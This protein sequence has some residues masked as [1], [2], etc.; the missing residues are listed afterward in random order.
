MDFSTTIADLKND[1]LSHL[2]LAL[3]DER[4]EVEINEDGAVSAIFGVTLAFHRE[5]GLKDGIVDSDGELTK[6]GA[7]RLQ[8]YLRKYLSEESG[9]DTSTLEVS[10]DEQTS[11]LGEDPGFAVILTSTPGLSTKF[12]KYWDETLWPF[13]ATMINICDPGTFNAPYMFD[14][15]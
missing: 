10:A 7:E 13:S 6:S 9:L 12:Q 2:D 3:D 4:F 5:L 8:T 1:T 11:T 14:H 15:I